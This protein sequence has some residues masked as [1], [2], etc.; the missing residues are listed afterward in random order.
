MLRL[1]QNGVKD[2]VFRGEFPIAYHTFKDEA[3]PVKVSM[4][5]FSPFIPLNEKDSSLPVVFFFITVENPGKEPVDLTLLSSLQNAVGRSLGDKD[6]G[7]SSIENK[8]YGG[9]QCER[10]Q[11]SAWACAE[12]TRLD[13]PGSMV[14][15]ANAPEAEML[16]PWTGYKAFW[17]TFADGS[18]KATTGGG[19][20]SPRG[21]T[22]NGA[23][24]I[25]LT[26]KPGEK[27][28]ANFA[29]AWHLPGGPRS[30][31]MYENSF[32]KADNVCKYADEQLRA[33]CR[34]TRLFHDTF[35]AGTLPY[36]VLDRLSSQCSTLATRVVNWTKA[37][38]R[39]RLGGPELLPR[40]LHARLEL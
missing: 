37:G 14:L 27:R 9:N 21:E 31:H 12:M 25:P 20:P 26:V 17:E 15:V 1:G 38:Q 30:T 3:L 36:Y 5:S 22:H 7:P 32:G 13:N 8:G 6:S 11:C 40:R 24:R 34:D 28:T 16:K 19:G 29:W 4:E 10:L 18:A 2:I 23:V 35:F 33:P 39:L